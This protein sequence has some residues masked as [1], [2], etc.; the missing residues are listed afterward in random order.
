MQKQNLLIE[1]VDGSRQWI[2]NSTQDEVCAVKG[3]RRICATSDPKFDV[4]T[5]RWRTGE[6]QFEIVKLPPYGV[7]EQERAGSRSSSTSI[8]LG[9]S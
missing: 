5:F 3:F 9:P 8:C 7:I 2:K 1:Y 4:Y 6:S